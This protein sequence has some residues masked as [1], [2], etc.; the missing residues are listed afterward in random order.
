MLSL[1]LLAAGVLSTAMAQESWKVGQAVKTT[2]GTIIGHPARLK[3]H[4]VV[5][6]YLGIPYV[7]PPVGK[8]RWL[9]PQPFKGNGTINADKFV[10]ST[11]SGHETSVRTHAS[12]ERKFAC[13]LQTQV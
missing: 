5:S 10:S 9:A 2:S 12:R 7:A 4:E 6:E 3:G 11:S 13:H 1:A 8:L